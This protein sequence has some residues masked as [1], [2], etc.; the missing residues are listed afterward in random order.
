MGDGA[1]P[2]LAQLLAQAPLDT[3]G[4]TTPGSYQRKGLR[5]R[6]LRKESAGGDGD[7]DRGDTG[8][9]RPVRDAR[10]WRPG[11]SG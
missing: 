8:W 7:G 1:D 4:V 11:V 3:T 5:T 2:V 6:A 9:H 10:V